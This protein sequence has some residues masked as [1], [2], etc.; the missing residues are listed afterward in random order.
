[1]SEFHIKQKK[2]DSYVYEELEHMKWI[3]EDRN[4][5]SGYL[6][7]KECKGIFWH[8]E[9]PHAMEWLHGCT[10]CETHYTHKI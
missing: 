9:K 1:M 3:C 5:N 10:Y 8:E 2:P 4:L 6:A 7:E